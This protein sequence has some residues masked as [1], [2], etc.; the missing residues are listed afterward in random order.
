MW[1]PPRTNSMAIVSLVM[2]IASLVACPLT[3]IVGVITGYSAKRQIRESAGREQGEGLAI[4]GIITSIIGIVVIIGIVL[5]FVLVTFLGTNASS[6]F[7]S[8]GS[9]VGGR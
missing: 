7:S 8:V 4:A 6:K 2:G 9:A 1:A 3:G 5:F